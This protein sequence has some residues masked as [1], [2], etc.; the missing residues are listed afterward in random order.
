MGAANEILSNVAISERDNAETARSASEAR[1][2]AVTD[3]SRGEVERYVAPDASSCYPL[4]YAFHLLGDIRNKT[5]VDLGCGTGINM[6]P[7]SKRGADVIGIDL[8]P[9]L[10]QHALQRIVSTNIKGRALIGSA[11]DTG[12]DNESVDVIFCAALVHHLDILRVRQEMRRILKKGGFVILYEP[13]R[14]SKFYDRLRKMLPSQSDV[15]DFEHP[16]TMLELNCI[17]ETFVREEQ[18]LFRLPFAAISHRLF[19]RPSAPCYKTSDWLI[20]TW[21]SLQHFATSV[22]V[23]LRK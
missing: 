5:V 15:S 11:Y 8:S 13:V 10:I 12:F 9:D 17:C 3:I 6:V 16:L 23:R 18:R 2:F 7:L 22:V 20:R 14:F 19:D 21:P 1:K 4:E